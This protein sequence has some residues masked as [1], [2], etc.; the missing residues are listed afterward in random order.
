MPHVAVEKIIGKLKVIK[1][2]GE[3]KNRRVIGGTVIE[4]VIRINALFKLIRRDFEIGNGKI[5]NLQSMKIDTKEV[6]EGSQCGMEVEFK[7][8]IIP[9]DIILVSEI[10]KVRG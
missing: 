3:N 4:G 1:S 8:D 6:Q 10:E 9:G 5:V 7:L 2:F